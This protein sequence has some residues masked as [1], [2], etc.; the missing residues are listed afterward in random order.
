MGGLE[1]GLDK[2]RE[3]ERELSSDRLTC[4][5]H[6]EQREGQERINGCAQIDKLIKQTNT[7]ACT[8]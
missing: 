5:T 2:M 6:W 1:R 7:S 8:Q 4:N 3:R